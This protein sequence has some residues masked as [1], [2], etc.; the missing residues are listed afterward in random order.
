[1]WLA[2][3]LVI[4]RREIQDLLIII[5]KPWILKEYLVP[6]LIIAYLPAIKAIDVIVIN[7]FGG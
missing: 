7:V 5:E 6:Y 3:K 2:E 1:M 4:I